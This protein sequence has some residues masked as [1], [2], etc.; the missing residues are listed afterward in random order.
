MWQPTALL[1][2]PGGIKGF[3]LLGFLLYMEKH[4]LLERVTAY[5]GVSVG[6]IIS[7][8]LVCG[9]NIYEV[10]NEASKTNLF[11]DISTIRLED[12][13]Q[14]IG[15]ISHHK[16]REILEKLVV[17]KFGKLLNMYELYMATGIELYVT[18]FELDPDN[19][20]PVHFSYKS[21]PNISPV[22]AVLLSMNI[23]LV[24][25]RLFRDGKPYVDGAIGDPYPI[26]LL[27]DG[28]KDVLGLYIAS[29]FDKTTDFL[30]Y[31]KQI[32]YGGMVQLRNISIKNASNRCQHICLRSTNSDSLSTCD[33]E[34]INMVTQGYDIAAKFFE[35]QSGR[36]IV[37]PDNIESIGEENTLE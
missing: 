4:D 8:L 1:L 27:D 11:Q 17:A 18:S 31:L 25:Q 24:F 7:L 14:N 9:Y 13:L 5:A 19:P 22:E 6:A 20:H 23:P 21:H 33:G 29:T 16:I 30:S 32:F 35:K 10:I 34:K 26:H 28:E 36:L 2:G 15:V 12:V 37:S 3:S